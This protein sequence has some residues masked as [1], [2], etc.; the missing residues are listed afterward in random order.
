VE[1]L[2]SVFRDYGMNIIP[3][4]EKLASF[5]KVENT[6]LAVFMLLGTLGVILGTVG[7]GVVLISNMI[8][9]KHELSVYIALGYNR[10][11]ILK[12]VMAE[13]LMIFLAGTGLGVVSALCGI[14]P[15]LLSPACQAP[16]LLAL[17]PVPVLLLNG[18]LWVWLS[19][20]AVMTSLRKE[21]LSKGLAI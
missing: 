17:L 11:Y 1:T 18:M 6:Y 12:L 8:E 3:A 16:G 7:L 9:R 10:K 19:A 13:Y 14:F 5:N 4:R 15:S 2:E 20:R 21:G